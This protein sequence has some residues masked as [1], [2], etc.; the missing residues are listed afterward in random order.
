MYVCR[1]TR[2]RQFCGLGTASAVPGYRYCGQTSNLRVPDESADLRTATP[3]YG[4]H[5]TRSGADNPLQRK[6]L[7]QCKRDLNQLRFIVA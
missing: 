4:G 6:A 7:R 3:A 5:D 1:M 2:L